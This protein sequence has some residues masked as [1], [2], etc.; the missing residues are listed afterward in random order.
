M[1]G[2]R[3]CGG[4]NAAKGSARGGG[5]SSRQR[6]GKA[7][8]W[9]VRLASDSSSVA[10][11]TPSG[12]AKSSSEGGGALPVSLQVTH[13]AA[14]NAQMHSSNAWGRNGWSPVIQRK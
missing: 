1:S 12:P 3:G 2:A 14:C 9:P 6:H 13:S 10:R 11:A 5:S 7:L 4:G 8:T